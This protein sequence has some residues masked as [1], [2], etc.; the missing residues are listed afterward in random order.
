MLVSLLA[1]SHTNT[2]Y[3]YPLNSKVEKE[4]YYTKLTIDKVA[5]SP[6][7]KFS[8]FSLSIVVV[9]DISEKSRFIALSFQSHIDYDVSNQ[10]ITFQKKTDINGTSYNPKKIPCH[11]GLRTIKFLKKIINLFIKLW[12]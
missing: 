3:N 1:F 2:Y 8:F 11:I 7:W 10:A 4:V 6:F 5:I 12:F 9:V